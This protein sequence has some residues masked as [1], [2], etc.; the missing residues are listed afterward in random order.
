MF[1]S[2]HIT[3]SDQEEAE[4][5]GETVVKERLAA[6]ANIVPNIRSVYWWNDTLEK[7]DETLLILK[8]TEENTETIIR[9]IKEL[10]SYE[11][12]CIVAL[13]IIKGSIEYLKWIK[14]ETKKS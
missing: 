1:V 14:E 2:I 10:H 6:C 8:T 4:K 9:R 3:S 7:S 5:I 12:P 11:N 13:P